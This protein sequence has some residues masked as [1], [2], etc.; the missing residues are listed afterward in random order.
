MELNKIYNED[1]LVGMKDI[2]D[3]SIDM[4][5]TDPPY[6]I[7]VKNN[8]KTMGRIGDSQERYIK[9]VETGEIVMESKILNDKYGQH[10]KTGERN[11]T[12]TK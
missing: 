9:I 5:L 1:C 7:S 8:F 12:K 11:D 2:P 6:N 4:L 10:E 3:K